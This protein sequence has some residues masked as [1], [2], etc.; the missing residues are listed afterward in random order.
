MPNR[1]FQN[2]VPGARAVCRTSLVLTTA[3]SFSIAVHA[4]GVDGHRAVANLAEARLSTEAK[5]EVIRLLA[6]E[7]GATLASVS[8]YADEHRDRSTARWHYVN[9]PRDSCN[10]QVKRDCP[11]GQCVVT[12]L[13]T[14]VKVLASK[15]PDEQRL[16]ALKWLVHLVGDIH[17]PLHAGYGDDRGGNS[18]QLQAFGRG[19]NMH[20]LWDVGL[21]RGAGDDAV[22]LTKRLL[23][24]Q[25]PPSETARTSAEIAEESCRIVSAPDFYPPRTLEQQY[26]VKYSHVLDDRLLLAGAR[27]ARLL[28]ENLK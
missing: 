20:A 1:L 17:Q 23:T 28:N 21:I 18:Y 13:D 24:R 9:F 5:A 16:L 8:T 6:I 10:Y 26:V 3:F 22:S 27:L 7:P 19:T 12:A 2:V 15:A 11:D 14:Q 4:W 25:V